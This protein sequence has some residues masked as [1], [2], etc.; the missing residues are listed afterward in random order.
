MSISDFIKVALVLAVVGVFGFLF[1]IGATAMAPLNAMNELNDRLLRE[2]RLERGQVVSI[3]PTTTYVND[4]PVA[5]LVVRYGVAGQ[6]VRAEFSQVIPHVYLPRVQPGL[7]VPLR[8][9]RQNPQQLVI[10]LPCLGAEAQAA[11]TCG[12]R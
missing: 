9:D 3:R 8:V 1:W 10:D 2:G 12:E 6:A 5:Q 4:Q 7:D 11:A